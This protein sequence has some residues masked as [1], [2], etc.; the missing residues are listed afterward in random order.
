MLRCSSTVL[1]MSSPCISAIARFWALGSFGEC[2]VVRHGECRFETIERAA[3]LV[4]GY[5]A[6]CGESAQLVEQSCLDVAYGAGVGSG[7][8]SVEHQESGVFGACDRCVGLDYRAVAVGHKV[9]VEA[10]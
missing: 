4:V 8:A 7:W 1:L 6:G 9:A 3:E 2:V 10:C 5:F